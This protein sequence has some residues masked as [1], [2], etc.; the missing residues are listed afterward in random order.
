MADFADTVRL[1]GGAAFVALITFGAYGMTEASLSAK[2]SGHC[3]PVEV[4]VHFPLGGTELN[5]FAKT[6]LNNAMN[7]TSHCKL[8][9]V[10]VFGFADASGN[11]ELNLEISK[12]RADATLSY[13]EA[14]GIKADAFMVD[15]RGEEGATRVDGE[16][17]VMRRKADLR[18]IPRE[19]ET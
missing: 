19:A 4:S 1:L 9:R 18:L 15:A 8:A 6:V 16:P 5:E 17:E 11:E 10:E 3:E 12:A 13:L 2:A 7:E 14:A